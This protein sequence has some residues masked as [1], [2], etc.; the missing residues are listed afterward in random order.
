MH[1]KWTALTVTTVGN[2]MVGLDIRILIIGLP[3]IAAQLH[4]GPEEVIWITQAYLLAGTVTLLLFGRMGDLFGRV[5]LYNFGLVIFTIGSA[6]CAISLNTTQLIGFRLVQGIGSAIL[7]SSALAILTDA[8]PRRQLGTMMGIATLAFRIGGVSGLTLSGVILSLT[9]WRGLF[10]VNVPI[11]IFGTLWA[12]LKLR[13][14]STQDTSKKMDWPGF[15]LFSIGLT[16][17][18]LAITFLS[19]GIAQELTGFALLIA[20]TILLAFFVMVESRVLSPILDLKLF[21]IKIFAAANV[22]QMLNT[23]TWSGI[24]LLSAFYLQI[25]LG[26]APLKAGI[27]IIP[28]EA[29]YFFSSLINGRL[30]D[31]YG[32]RVLCTSGLSIIAASYIILSTF[33][34]S[35]PYWHVA[36]MLAFIGYGNGM[37]TPPNTSAIMMSVPE[38]RRGIASSFREIMFN[39]G[40][41]MSFGLVVLFITFGI[42]YATFNALLQ[43]AGAQ[44]LGLVA[45]SQFIGGFRIAA[46]LLAAIDAI[47]VIP[48]AFRGPKE[49]QV[50]KSEE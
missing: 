21:K 48:S 13:E 44:S 23:I 34:I 16:M 14:I 45:Q 30:S 24:L 31:K 9:N 6:L 7:G 39:S 4:A 1:Y 25:G 50:K 19:Y 12:Y 47:A 46:L 26:Y 15:A 8:T 3:T 38:N 42:P 40:S 28:V 2:L 37:F 29:T 32:S 18:L 33:G 36:L 11:G 20:G 27:A 10:Y 17:V 35:T 43:G 22:A 5:K 49:I 41:T